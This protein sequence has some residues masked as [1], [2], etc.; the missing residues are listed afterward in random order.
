MVPFLGFQ[1]DS[2]VH[3]G[4]LALDNARRQKSQICILHV[5]RTCF[6][7]SL[8]P[9]R[10]RPPEPRNLIFCRFHLGISIGLTLIL[11]DL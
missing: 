11:D 8:L 6:Q 7:N 3:G 1:E 10:C 2:A 9:I 5:R 4:T